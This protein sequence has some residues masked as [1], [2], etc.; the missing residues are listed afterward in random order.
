[1]NFHCTAMHSPASSSQTSQSRSGCTNSMQ[2]GIV[3]Q[4]LFSQ[5]PLVIKHS[6]RTP[7][8]GQLDRRLWCGFHPDSLAFR[9]HGFR[10]CRR[11]ALRERHPMQV[12]YANEKR[13]LSRFHRD[14]LCRMSAITVFFI[15]PQ[16][17][18]TRLQFSPIILKISGISPGTAVLP[19][20]FS[21]RR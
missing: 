20:C 3:Q 8:L 4:S 21:S 15:I 18:S 5:F 13:L 16:N 19:A 9:Y 6:L 12:L 2:S 10:L 7:R 1:M 17:R 14:L 11:T